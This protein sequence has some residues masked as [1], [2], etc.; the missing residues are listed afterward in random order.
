MSEKL[1]AGAPHRVADLTDIDHFVVEHDADAKAVNELTAM[2]REVLIA[3][4]AP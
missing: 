4:S 2:G 1:A 3:D